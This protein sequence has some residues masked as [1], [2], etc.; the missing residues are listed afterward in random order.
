MLKRMKTESGATDVLSCVNGKSET[1]CDMADD[2]RQLKQ[3]LDDIYDQ[4]AEAHCAIQTNDFES[5]HLVWQQV[6]KMTPRIK[7][8]LS[9]L[10]QQQLLDEQLA[11]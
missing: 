11:I 10:A 1:G 3:W 4:V 2:L 6:A 8:R 7:L 5:A 9:I